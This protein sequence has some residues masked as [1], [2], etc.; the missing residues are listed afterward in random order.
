MNFVTNTLIRINANLL[1]TGTNSLVQET[2]TDDVYKDFYKDKNLF[3]FGDYPQDSK[4]F[5]LINNKV[6]GAMKD[7]FTGKIIIEFVG[8]KSKMCSL[9][10]ADEEKVKK[11]KGVNKIVVKRRQKYRIV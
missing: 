4:F 2:E 9:I 1:F 8:L 3:D 5:D 7:E 11:A 10:A 6:N